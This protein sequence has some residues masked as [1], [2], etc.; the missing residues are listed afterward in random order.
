M[1]MLLQWNNVAKCDWGAAQNIALR[2]SL[3]VLIVLR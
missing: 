1:R 2:Y 3:L